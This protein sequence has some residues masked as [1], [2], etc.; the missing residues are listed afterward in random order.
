[1][2]VFNLLCFL[3]CLYYNGVKHSQKANYLSAIKCKFV[4]FGLDVACFNDHRLKYYQRAVQLH[5]PLKVKLNKIINVNLLKKIVA[6]CDLTYMGQIFKGLY[7]L[8]FF[9]FL[10]L[11]NLVPHACA[12]FPHL[13]I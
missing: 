4:I 6:Q 10:R 9:S 13:N 8:S 3:E 12:G 7:L 1:M 2:N 11:S 5:A